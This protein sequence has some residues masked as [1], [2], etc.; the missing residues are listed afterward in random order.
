MKAGKHLYIQGPMQT[1]I[2]NM[3]DVYNYSNVNILH[4]HPYQTVVHLLRRSVR[5]WV[6]TA[7]NGI[8]SWLFRP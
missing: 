7:P 4:R 2:G 3:Y 8:T 5:I 6:P 1:Y